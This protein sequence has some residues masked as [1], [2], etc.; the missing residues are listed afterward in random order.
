MRAPVTER[1]QSI[2]IDAIHLCWV[3][4]RQLWICKVPVK[5][6]CHLTGTFCN[7]KIMLDK[8]EYIG[9]YKGALLYTCFL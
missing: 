2:K 9:Q 1:A 6:F 5:R 3:L 7:A 4:V 8:S